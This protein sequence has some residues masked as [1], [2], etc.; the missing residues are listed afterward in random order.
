MNSK[1]KNKVKQN[2]LNT[3]NIADELQNEMNEDL[4][5]DILE[6]IDAIE[7]WLEN[8]TGE[9]ADKFS[10]KTF[11]C[12]KALN[13]DVKYN[14]LVYSIK[15]IRYNLMIYEIMKNWEYLKSF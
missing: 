4:Q 13:Q 9:H 7:K 10:D 5:I 3:K 2:L 12:A 8:D 15:K 6:M 11:S 14:K 1:I